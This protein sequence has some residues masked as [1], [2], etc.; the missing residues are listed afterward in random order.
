V[1][2]PA[3][4]STTAEATVTAIA[5]TGTVSNSVVTYPT[6]VTL[7]TVPPGLRLGQS[8]QVAITTK[9]SAEGALYIPA[10]AITTTAGGDSS[11]KIVDS[12]GTTSTVTVTLGVVG[13]VGTEIVS[14]LKA[15]QTVVLG[16]VSPA[17]TG[18]RTG[19][20]NTGNNTRGGFGGGGGLRGGGLGFGENAG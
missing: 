20:A 8:A 18:S 17:T 6:T 15:G 11:V 7:S 19:G 5:P 9:S 3:M 12:T 2:F 13:T 10:E 16:T 14:G 1:T 4:T